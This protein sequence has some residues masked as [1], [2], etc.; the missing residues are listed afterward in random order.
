MSLLRSPG[1]ALW[2]AAVTEFSCFLS[3]PGCEEHLCALLPL[4]SPCHV[5][6]CTPASTPPP[7]IPE[8]LLRGK[9]TQNP[10]CTSGEGDVDK[11]SEDCWLGG[12]SP[13][14]PRRKWHFSASQNS[15]TTF[16]WPNGTLCICDKG[17]SF[18][19]GNIFVRAEPC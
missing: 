17:F 13:T 19:T 9:S 16:E 12:S 8:Q 1:L 7:P 10:E 2:L 11:Q 15:M 18:I 14:L 3:Q 4:P 6:H 5:P